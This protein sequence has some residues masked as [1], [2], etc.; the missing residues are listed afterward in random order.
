MV[1]FFEIHI[2]FSS[3]QHYLTYFYSSKYLKHP[4]HFPLFHHLLILFIFLL[5][6]PKKTH[7][8]KKAKNSSPPNF[9]RP[10]LLLVLLVPWKLK[11]SSPPIHALLI[12]Q[13]PMKIEND[14]PSN[15]F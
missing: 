7:K 6:F 10:L 1:F 15:G 12:L 2:N 8:K 13:K 14:L 3:S 4:T 11:K 9:S 5:P